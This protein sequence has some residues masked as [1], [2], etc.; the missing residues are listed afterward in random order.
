M[1]PTI[2]IYVQQIINKVYPQIKL[3]FIEPFY[4]NPLYIEALSDSI[5]P[6]LQDI[7]K[8]IFSYHGIPERHIKKSDSSRNHCFSNSSCCEIEC[9]ESQNCYRSNVLKTSK[10]VAD[11]L[12]LRDSEWMVTFQSRVTI[13]DRK[14]LKPFTD[15]ELIEGTNFEYNYI[16]NNFY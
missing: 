1:Y 16:V 3:S 8:L 15:I 13:I 9:I 11:R 4:D 12:T 6:Y 2:K 10:L 7:D 5:R 14:W